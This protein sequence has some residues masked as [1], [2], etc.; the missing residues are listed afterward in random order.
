MYTINDAGGMYISFKC[1]QSMMLVECTF[2]T[3]KDNA[4][5]ALFSLKKFH[6]KVSHRILRHMHVVL[7]VDEK[8]N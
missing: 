4:S 1:I 8:Q 6:P 2:S 7:N 3:S 5:K